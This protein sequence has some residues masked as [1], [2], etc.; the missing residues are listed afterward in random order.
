MGANGDE[1]EKSESLSS[2][3]GYPILDLCV[4]NHSCWKGGG[5]RQEERKER[6]GIAL[7]SRN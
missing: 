2:G 4:H 3:L 5:Q 7:Q 1:Y 6:E